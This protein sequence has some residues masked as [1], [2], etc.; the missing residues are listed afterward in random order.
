MAG[1][2]HQLIGNTRLVVRSQICYDRGGESRRLDGVAWQC[3][4]QPQTR[5]ACATADSPPG[6]RAQTLRAVRGRDRH[7]G[8]MSERHKHGV[9]VS[10]PSV[11]GTL[12]SLSSVSKALTRMVRTPARESILVLP[13]EVTVQQM[14]YHF[15]SLQSIMLRCVTRKGDL[16]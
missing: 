8:G 11:R 15:I 3:P 7:A 9:L 12:S 14:R 10:S 6:C 5:S 16:R 2:K 1:G 4:R 13:G